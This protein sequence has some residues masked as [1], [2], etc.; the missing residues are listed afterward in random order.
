VKPNNAAQRDTAI[1]IGKWWRGIGL[2]ELELRAVVM[3]S[4]RVLGFISFSP[5][6]QDRQ[7]A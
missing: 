5:T 6:Y 3:A 4:V 2:G 7:Q 1:L